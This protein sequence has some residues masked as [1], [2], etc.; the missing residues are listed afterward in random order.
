MN[1][2]RGEKRVSKKT[3]KDWKLTSSKSKIELTNPMSTKLEGTHKLH[4]KVHLRTGV[5]KVANTAAYWWVNYL[6][7][8]AS[9]KGI[10]KQMPWN[11]KD[12]YLTPFLE[13]IPHIIEPSFWGYLQSMKE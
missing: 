12:N 13:E 9:W 5:A 7:M 8:M 11:A 6:N 4:L 3:I 2:R 1:Y 10:W